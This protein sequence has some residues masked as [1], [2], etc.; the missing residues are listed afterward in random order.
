MASNKACIVTIKGPP[1]NRFRMEKI[2]KVEWNKRV[3][4]MHSIDKL[5]A[6]WLRRAIWLMGSYNAQ[7]HAQT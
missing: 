6:K 7:L 1:K 5:L 3:E 4:E 2:I